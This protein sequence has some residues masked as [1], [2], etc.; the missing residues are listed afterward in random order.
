M[1]SKRNSFS[2][3]A[4]SL[5]AVALTLLACRSSPP[6]PQLVNARRAYDLAQVSPG[7]QLTPDQLREAR[8]ALDAAEAMHERDPGSTGE[9]H[10]A[11]LADRKAQ[12]SLAVGKIAEAKQAE[13]EAKGRAVASLAAGEAAGQAQSADQARVEQERRAASERAIAALTELGTVGQVEKRDQGTVVTIPGAAL[14]GLGKSELSASAPQSLDKLASALRQQAPADKI[15]IE[16]YTDSR[17]SDETNQQLSQ[18]RAEAVRD[19]LVRAGID[20]AELEAIGRGKT[21]PIAS[22]DTAEGRAINRRVEILIPGPVEQ[23]LTL[24]R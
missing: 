8:Q 19:Y 14:F 3:L 13:Q 24:A 15:R 5:G 23:T 17:G 20:A 6:T 16:G 21:N 9:A 12:Q 11:Y 2:V 4:I 22:N 10:L 1:K 7:A 18:E